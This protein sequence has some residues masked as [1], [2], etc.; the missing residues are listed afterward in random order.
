MILRMWR[1]SLYRTFT[2]AAGIAALALASPVL[3]QTASGQYE[4]KVGQQGK[5]VVWVPTPA[6]MVEKMLDLAGVTP[7][8]MVIDLGSGDGRNVI[9]AAKRGARALGVEYNPD[10]VEYSRRTAEKQGVGDKAKFVQGDMYEADISEATVL[11]LFLLPSNLERLMP[12]FLALAPGT[13]IVANTFGLS[14]WTAE[15]TTS[16]ADGCVS[17][18]EAMLYIVPA[19]VQGTWSLGPDTLELQ[20]DVQRLSGT[21]KSGE[22]SVPLESGAIKGEVVTFAAAG[23]TYEGRVKGDTF[24]GVVKDASG[25]K[26]FT[27]RR[28][29]R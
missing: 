20:Q 18:C 19:R 24:D 13:R 12:K 7:K 23:K 9:A 4:P 26:R 5:D 3:A 21:L 11:A 22:Q 2:I 28:V 29:S 6:E 17:W 14:G 15:A 8:D 16:L 10:L 27:A 1:S 25:E